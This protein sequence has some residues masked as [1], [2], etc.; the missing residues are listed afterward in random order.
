MTQILG[1]LRTDQD[2]ELLQVSV[3][4]LTDWANTLGIAFNVKKCLVMHYR[5]KNP[6]YPY[7]MQGEQLSTK[8][9]ERDIGVLLSYN[10][11]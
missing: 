5:H 3:D 9:E 4:K 10:L 11:K 2:R 6:G 1:N 7:Y 8:K